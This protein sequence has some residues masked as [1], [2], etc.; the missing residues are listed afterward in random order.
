MAAQAEEETKYCSKKMLTSG[1]KQASEVPEKK[2]P[3]FLLLTNLPIIHNKHKKIEP[4][5]K[6]GCHLLQSPN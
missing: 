2:I 3:V 4:L 1:S 6:E 5:A